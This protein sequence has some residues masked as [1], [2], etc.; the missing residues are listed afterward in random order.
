MYESL[1]NHTLVSDGSQSH[2]DLLASAEESGFGVIA[3]TDHDALPSAQ[4]MLQLEGYEGPVKWLIGC[5]ISCG[6]VGS[7]AGA[8]KASMHMLGLF[9]DIH[10]KNLVAHC[11]AAQTA[12]R[13]RILRLVQNLS[14]LGFKISVDDVLT[15]SGGES[16]GR[17]HIVRALAMHERNQAV[18]N[19]IQADMARAATADEAIKADYDAMCARPHSIPYRLFLSDDSFI[20]GV[21]VDYLYYVDMD[22]AVQLIRGAGGVAVLAHWFTVRKHLPIDQLEL[23]LAEQRLDGAEIQNNPDN[24]AATAAVPLL[25][26]ALKATGALVTY[27]VDTHRPQDLMLYAAQRGIAEQTVGHTSRLIAQAAPSLRFSN[28]AR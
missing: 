5:E 11:A 8:A 10:E 15:Q 27:G 12:R 20:R 7:T 4:Q 9:I 23:L 24:P 1:H 17:P 26:R 25:T 22:Q 13:E 19:A 6:M 2:L 16:I 21:Y 14:N 28:L 3:F 18:M